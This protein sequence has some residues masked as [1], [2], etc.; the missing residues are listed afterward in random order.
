MKKIYLTF[1]VVLV[2][3]I[4]FAQNQAIL[5]KHERLIFELRDL[6][7]I[8]GKPFNREVA[9]Q[10][11]K[12]R[13]IAPADWNEIINLASQW[14]KAHSSN[15]SRSA[16]THQHESSKVIPSLPTINNPNCPNAGFENGNFTNWTGSTYT[17]A[18]TSWAT[19]PVWTNGFVSN[20]SNAPVSDPLARHTLTT[21][22]ATNNNPA[23]GPLIG[24]D[25]LSINP[26]TGLATIPLVSPFGSGISARLGNANY[27]SE[28]E[29]LVF[30]MTVSQA[31]AQYTFQY[32]IVLHDPVSH[33]AQEQ[34]QFAINILDQNGNTIGGCAA[35]SI[36]VSQAATDPS[37][38]YNP[39]VSYVGPGGFPTTSAVYFKNWTTIGVNLS[40]YIGQNIQIEF[41]SFDCALGGHF[42]YAY[43]DAWCGNPTIPINFCGSTSATLVGPAG[44]VGYQWYG[45]NNMTPIAGATNDTLIVSNAVIGNVYTLIAT[46]QN[47]CNVT[48]AA[49]IVPSTVG[50]QSVNTTPSCA[51]GNSG[52]ASIVA[53]GSSLGN[54]T[55]SW[56]NMSN[57]AVVST[58]ANATGLSPG[59]Y[60]VTV[61]HPACGTADSIITVGVSPPLFY[62]DV[63]NFCLSPATV[64]APSGTNYVWYNSNGTVIPGANTANLTVNNPVNN[65]FYTVVFNNSSGCKDSVKITT[66]QTVNQITQN[67]TF[68]GTTANLCAPAGATNIVWY[69]ANWP[70]AVIGNGNCISIPNPIASTWQPYYLSYTNPTTGCKDSVNISL[71]NTP[72]SIYASSIVP[73]CLG[74]STGS[75]TINLI[76]GAPAG[77]Y[78]LT[79]TGPTNLTNNAAGATQ[80][81]SNLPAGTY[82]IS[83]TDGQCTATS[84]FVV[85][86]IFVNVTTSVAPDTI[87]GGQSAVVTFNYGGGAPTQ[88]A[89]ATSGCASTTTQTVGNGTLQ[90]TSTTWPSPYGNWYANEKYQI[91]YT[92]AD[93]LASGLTPGKITSIAFNV[94]SIPA[95]MNTTFLNYR[96]KIGC[97]SVGDLDPTGTGFNVPFQPNVNQQVFGPQNY[98]VTAGWNTHNFTTAYEWDGISNI[99]VEICYDWVA[100]SNYTSNAIM[101]Q[102]ATGYRSFIV[103]YSDVTQA[104]PQTLA[105]ASYAQ[106][107]NTR[108]NTCQSVASPN[109]FTYSWSPNTGVSG[110]APTVN[111][112]PSTSTVYTVSI[113]S[114][115]GGC[116][117]QDTVPITVINPF[118]VTMPPS[119]TYCV[120]EPADQF[121]AVI[122]PAGGS[123]VW[124]GPGMTDSGNNADGVFN[125]SAAGVGNWTLTFTAGGGGCVVTNTVQVT[126]NNSAN[127]TINPAGP[128][129][130]TDNAVN[131]TTVSPGGTFSGPGITNPNTGTFSPAAAG[132]GTATIQY[133]IGGNC[134][135]NGQLNIVV[136]PQPVISISSNLSQGCVPSDITFSANV[137][138]PGNGNSQWFFG[139]GNISGS[140]NPLHTYSD[141]GYFDVT[142]IYVDGNGCSDTILNNNMIWIH[143]QATAAFVANPNE[144]TIIDPTV[145]FV[146]QS[147][148]AISYYW[149]LT[150]DSSST[151]TNPVWNYTEPGTY[152][153]MLIA[154]NQ[155][156]CNDTTYNTVIVNPDVALYVPN[157][158][159]P[160]D[161]N[162]LNDQ[163]IPYLSGTDLSSFR[164]E[165]YDR[166]GEQIYATED[167][168]K[169]W[170]GRKNNNGELVQID[171]YV[172]KIY[173]RNDENK[174]ASKVGHVTILK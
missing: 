141:T 115:F 9:R 164:M 78:S 113:T 76:S 83:F 130:I 157:A 136:Y 159:T 132:A 19:A 174:A 133:S 30:P 49:T 23:N 97:T 111:L 124:T 95:G 123:G 60:S 11:L 140:Q 8:K 61:S 153:I 59:Q 167:I 56:V 112:T 68:C 131:L 151:L 105:N 24:Y 84:S 166:W 155:W 160:G 5:N 134:P 148:N 52:S 168:T 53:S 94:A 126:V 170:N 172:W 25:S 91:L 161:E 28:T 89:A 10:E 139:D 100:T 70:Y 82:N 4:C 138:A 26:T 142:Y 45:P 147:L 114:N 109:D 93:L 33:A 108:F 125:P 120:S 67:T 77:T 144:T 46:A 22:P 6:N 3:G 86:T 156:G 42:G 74:S 15:T 129:C 102:T 39:S 38:I 21:I 43:V 80:N 69:D 48:I 137:P 50:I 163:F 75:A 143:P 71:T 116:V 55:Y 152:N 118:T 162:N 81:L 110:T 104:C 12:K 29:R 37:F 169:G 101:N 79:V 13:N 34:P 58:A 106:R 65:S 135:A 128:F 145:Q 27:G 54:Y 20:G 96:V 51:T 87:C 146:N 149:Q 73:T 117:K 165:I 32:A 40:A 121:T 150:E 154:T 36:N 31:N 98:V 44:F 64:A 17:L 122:N 103:Y 88:C 85:D 63:Q 7:Q 72:S 47:G 119:Q 57:N 158:F 16:H 1:L 35:Y 14:H 127:G 173:Y 99:I 2:T 62:T 41:R 171:V 18:G 90:N 66:T 107:P 92:A